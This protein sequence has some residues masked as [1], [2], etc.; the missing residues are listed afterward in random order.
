MRSDT[1]KLDWNGPSELL[2]VTVYSSQAGITDSLFLAIPLWLGLLHVSDIDGRDQEKPGERGMTGNAAFFN[3]IKDFHGSV[4][5]YLECPLFTA[6][7]TRASCKQDDVGVVSLEQTGD[8]LS[9][10]VFQA[11]YKRLDGTWAGAWQLG[12]VTWIANLRNDSVSGL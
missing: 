2:A 9:T 12:S 1:L 4:S 6:F 11:L 8:L 7:P 3:R 10:E 5:V